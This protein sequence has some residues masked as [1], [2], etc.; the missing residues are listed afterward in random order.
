MISGLSRIAALS[1]CTFFAAV[2]AG[3]A[4]MRESSAHPVVVAGVA[5]V[6][7]VAVAAADTA[8]VARLLTAVRGVDPLLCELA[9]RN[10]DMHGSWSHWGPLGGNPL[11]VDSAAAALLEWIQRDHNDPAVVPRLRS[12]MRDADACVRRVAG[13]FLGRV[14]HPSARDAL[15]AALDDPK[16]ETRYV[17]A[18]GLGLSEKPAG[19]AALVKRLKDES[20]AV[21]RASAWALGSQEASAALTPLIETL[22]RD[23]DPRV[24]HAAA[25]AIGHIHE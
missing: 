2:T 19:V 5:G 12:A 13:S 16:A 8:L 17:A 9:T 18:L 11:E 25:W 20:A 1:G 22:E 3:A 4:C 6:A 15:L 10:V 24:R 23:S 14:D 7:G 21:R